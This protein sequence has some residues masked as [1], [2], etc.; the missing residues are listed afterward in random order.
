MGLRVEEG[1]VSV[2]EWQAACASGEMSE[3][4]ACGTAAVITP[5]GEVFSSRGGWKV[6]GGESGPV[7]STLRKA[8]LDIQT[9]AAPD[10]HG[11]LTTMV[12][13]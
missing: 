1:V 5:I 8:L 13:A 12:E 7:T 9:G 2:D 4:F 6:G 10:K 3:A 11:W